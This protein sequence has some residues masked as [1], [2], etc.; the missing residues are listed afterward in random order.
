MVELTRHLHGLLVKIKVMKKKII[1]WSSLVLVL[2]GLIV[3]ALTQFSYSKGVRSGRLVKLSKK[4]VVLPTYEGTLDL[5]SGDRLTWDFSVH[6]SQVA[7]ELTKL[8]GQQVRLE[9]RQLLF[10]LF[11]GSQYDVVKFSVVPS[12]NSNKWFCRLVNLMRK[13]HHVV[14]AVRQMIEAQD[15]ELM[16]QVRHCQR[17]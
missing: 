4:G 7:K 11:Y 15:P 9:Y 6:N 1:L 12:S 10:K 3:F 2:T 8:S 14:K 16:N 5:G 17:N 13:N